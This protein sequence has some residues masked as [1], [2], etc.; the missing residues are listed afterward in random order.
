MLGKTSIQSAGRD[1]ELQHRISDCTLQIICRKPPFVKFGIRSQKRTHKYLKRLLETLFSSK[2]THC[3][4]LSTEADID[5]Y[6]TLPTK[7]FFVLEMYY[8]HK[9]I[10]CVNV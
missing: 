4:R 8:F 7:C 1:Q 5:I 2:T 9:N 3:K 6:T 10:I